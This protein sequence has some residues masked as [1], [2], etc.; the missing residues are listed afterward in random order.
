VRSIDD[1]EGLISGTDLANIK[2]KMIAQT[3]GQNAGQPMVVTSR[4]TVQKTGLTPAELDVRASRYMSQETVT[5][6]TG[7]PAIVLNFGAGMERTIYNNME[8]AD[9]RAVDQ[10]LQPL[11]WHIAQEL[12]HQLLRD[13]DQDESHFVEFDLS[14]VGALQED[15]NEKVTRVVAMYQGQVIKRSEARMA[16]D[17]E[18]DPSGADDVYLVHAGS[19]TVTL[20]DETIKRE[21]SA[22]ATQNPPEPEPMMIE[23]APQRPQLVAKSL[24]VTK[25]EIREHWER[26]A[27]AR[28]KGLISAKAK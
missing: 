16:L 11:W 7:M 25:A 22:E 26:H 27:P 21:A 13:L 2:A 6:V 1:K 3:T 19:E 15:Q 10:Y 20:E 8:Q 24:G 4:A 17:Y 12:T 18:V 28:V 5:A 23:G 14:E 9:R